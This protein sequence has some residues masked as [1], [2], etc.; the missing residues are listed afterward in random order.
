MVDSTCDSIYDPIYVSTFDLTDVTQ[1]P[2]PPTRDQ[3][4]LIVELEADSGD[5]HCCP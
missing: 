3:D 2:N 5:H 1:H 4:L